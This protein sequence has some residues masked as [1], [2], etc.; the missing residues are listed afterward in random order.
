MDEYYKAADTLPSWLAYP[1]SQLPTAVAERVHEIRLRTGCG[2][3][4]TLNGKQ[5]PAAAIP[6]VPES[7]RELVL[8]QAQMDEVLFTLCGGSVHSHQ[9]EIAQ[10]YVRLPGGCRAGLG[11]TYLR[12]PDQGNLLQ[13]VR[14]VNLR[15]ARERMVPLPPDLLALLKEHFTGLLVVGEPD[16]VTAEHCGI[17]C[18]PAGS[19]IRDR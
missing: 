6:E 13:T 8:T 11:G 12:H 14:S 18:G 19:C 5:T 17:L 16:S 3:V 4:L 9:E 2:L 7:L 15:I 1:L 10:G